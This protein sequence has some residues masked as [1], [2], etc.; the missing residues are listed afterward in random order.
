MSIHNICMC[1]LK[2]IYN[3]NQCHFFCTRHN[4]DKA[5]LFIALLSTYQYFVDA[6]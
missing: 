6:H 5:R 4:D 2:Y 1:A 3:F